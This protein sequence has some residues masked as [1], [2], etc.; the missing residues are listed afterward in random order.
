[1]RTRKTTFGTRTKLT[2][3][4]AYLRSIIRFNSFNSYS[5]SFS[6]V[7]D[8]SLQLKKTPVANPIV[9]NPPPMLFP[10]TFKV[11]HNNLIS[12]KFG[13]NIFTDVVINP[14][15]ITSFSSREFFKQSLTGMSAFSLEFT[16]QVF[17]LSFDLLDF[18]RIIK[19]TVRTDSE[20]IYSEV[21]AQNNVLRTNVLLSGNNLFR[22]CEQEKTSSFFINLKQTFFDIPSEVVFIT[23]RNIEFELL[24]DF[25]QSQ[26]KLVSFNVCTSRKV[27]SDRC[28]LNDR[29]SFSFLDNTTSLFDTSDSKLS[30]QTSFP[31]GRINKRM[32]FDIVFNFTLPSLINTELQG[33]GVSFDCGNYLSSGI[34]SN[35]CSGISSHNRNKTQEVYKCIGLNNIM[36]V[37]VFPPTAKAVGILNAE[38][39]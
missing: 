26:D 8:K 39:L 12:I 30:W 20:V 14:S 36:E 17:E 2:T 27:I 29:F 11:F 37:S 22:E 1:M 15:H 19:P 9:H 33:F 34:D 25:E 35:L 5:F 23:S 10:Y 6:F 3:S 21:N 13:N 38:V 28:L 24:P 18:S 32:E 31:Q 16:T 4:M 7:L